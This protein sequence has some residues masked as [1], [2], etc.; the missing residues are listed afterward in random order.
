LVYEIFLTE[1][2]TPE[3][4]FDISDLDDFEIRVRCSIH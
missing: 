4:E 3:T 2:E 1:D